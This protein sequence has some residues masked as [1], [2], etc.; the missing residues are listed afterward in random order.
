MPDGNTCLQ[1]SDQ[2]AGAEH[3]ISTPVEFLGF[4][5]G[6]DRRLAD[7]PEIA[8]YFRMLGRLS[9]RVVT[10]EIGRTTEGNPF[11]MAVISSAENLAKIDRY[12][13][14]QKRLADPRTIGDDAEADRFITEGKVVVAVTCSIHATEVGATQMSPLLAHHI[15]TSDDE[16]V[17]RILDNVI[18]LLIPSLNPDGLISVKKWYDST[19]GT[20]YEGVMPPFLYHKYTGHDNNR[21]WFMFTQ[22]ETRLVLQHCFNAWHPQILYDLHQTRATGMRMIL[23]PF[24]D[25]VGPN[26]DPILQS[27][28]AM[29]GSSMAS[30]LTAQGKAGVAVNVV[31]DAYSPNRT[32]QHYH[33]G[34]RVISEAASVRIAS[35][36]EL[37]PNQ[38]SSDRGESPTKKSW[39]HP[40]PW[41]PGVW[42]LRDIVDYDFAAVM[43]C[44]N[45]AARNRDTWLRNFYKVG[46]A[47]LS[48]AGG[49][50]AYLIPTQQRD[51]PAASELLN[52]MEMGLVEI[53]EAVK[54][55][56]SNG[57]TYAPGT[58]VILTSQPYG[59]FAKTLLG[60][61]I[62]PDLRA[63]TDGAPVVPYDVTAHCLPIKMGVDV[64]EARSAFV[65]ELK[66]LGKIQP[67]RGRVLLNGKDKIKA[68]L[69][70]SE[71]NASFRAI[72]RFLEA[73]AKVSRAREPIRLNGSHFPQGTFVVHGSNGVSKVAETIATEESVDLFATS[74][75]PDTPAF[76]LAMPRIG[77]YRSYVPAVEEGWTRYVFDE[78]GFG[79][80]SINDGD[81]RRGDL[82]KRFDAIV[83][84]HQHTRHMHSG[85]SASYYHP[86]Y[87]GGLGDEGADMLKR[88]VEEG[89]TLVTWDSSSRYAIR[90]LELPIKNVLAG[91][92]HTEFFAPGTLVRLLLDTSHPLAYGMPD[93]AAAMFFNG[94]AFDVREGR[95]VGKYPL[96][97]PLLSGWLIGPEKLYGRAALATVPLGKGQVVLMS[98]RVHFRAQVRNTYKILFNSLY[99]SAVAREQ[100]VV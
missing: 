69:I 57:V 47:A 6:D 82:H 53:H 48:E 81:I 70:R 30:E 95:V 2:N 90:Y 24:V 14:I 98:F 79:Y 31:Y 43:A 23:P 32:Y 9:D 45:N 97:N 54:S 38:L 93:K 77:L 8:D 20:S 19:I 42:R 36:V 71:T 66:R 51:A 44:L 67:P 87:T 75:I 41:T 7:W 64:Y 17:L 27:E 88:F 76:E 3:K 85:H 13:A 37:Q 28:L 68:Y 29:L 4:E 1:L 22:V 11:I 73:G 35:P 99:H 52:V 63:E 34:I 33:G 60:P 89:G 84:P 59:A 16:G 58:R 86:D 100:Q 80:Q 15:A 65:A 50:F 25:P 91:V 12:R 18:L 96:G 56:Q 94:P 46:R 61:H 55:F 74:E 5:P 10:E 62:Y 83:L 49:P 92:T 40:M 39:N 26:V 72:N 21:D 78:Y